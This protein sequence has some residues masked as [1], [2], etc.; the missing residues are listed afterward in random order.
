MSN[1]NIVGILMK[2][3]KPTCL[4]RHPARLPFRGS[5]S[6]PVLRNPWHSRLPSG[7]TRSNRRISLLVRFGIW[8]LNE[9]AVCGLAQNFWQLAC[10]PRVGVGNRR[11]GLKPPS[12]TPCLSD[13]YPK[14]TAAPAPCHLRARVVFSG[15]MIGFMVGWLRPLKW[16][17]LA[18]GLLRRRLT[19]IA[20]AFAGTLPP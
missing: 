12:H 1:R 7:L 4:L 10:L 6:R 13:L 20:I 5:L 14:E 17:G 18:R 15:I 9:S 16:W 2:P 11:G 8:S 19:R 3:L